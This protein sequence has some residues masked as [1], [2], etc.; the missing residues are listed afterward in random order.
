MAKPQPNTLAK[1]TTKPIEAQLPIAPD[2]LDPIAK[3]CWQDLGK[4]LLDAGL[5]TPADT[6]AFSMLCV[7][8]SRFVR[9]EIL[10]QETGETFESETSAYPIHSTE[11]NISRA[12]QAMLQKMLKEFGL[13]PKSR[14]DMKIGKID[15]GADLVKFLTTKGEVAKAETT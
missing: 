12:A 15:K 2:W 9:N 13:S 6:I 11:L 7:N 14:S 4:I 8:W 5:I 3:Q 1:A 10:C